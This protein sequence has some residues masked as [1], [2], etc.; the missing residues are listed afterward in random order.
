MS[1]YVYINSF[2]IEKLKDHFTKRIDT[3]LTCE[4]IFIFFHGSY[5][6]R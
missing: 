4:Q 3:N 5:F 2:F 6:L 1:H